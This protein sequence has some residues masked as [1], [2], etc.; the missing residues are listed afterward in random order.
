MRRFHETQDQARLDRTCSCSPPGVR[1][2]E[3]HGPGRGATTFTETDHEAA[4]PSAARK[5]TLIRSS[6]GAQARRHRMVGT[7]AF[8]DL[9]QRCV[10]KCMHDLVKCM[11]DRVSPHPHGG[12]VQALAGVHALPGPSCGPL[13][14]ESG[15]LD[16]ESLTLCSSWGVRVVPHSER[17]PD[18]PAVLAEHHPGSLPPLDG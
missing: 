2:T 17:S 3:N 13:D 7:L 8:I 4:E 10:V 9:A 18:R 6:Q 1:S 12:S 15:P 11:H 5:S 16:G 14:G